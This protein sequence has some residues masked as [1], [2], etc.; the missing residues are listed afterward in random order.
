MQWSVYRIKYN[1]WLQSRNPLCPISF[2]RHEKKPIAAESKRKSK[3]RPDSRKGENHN[4]GS[5]FGNFEMQNPEDQQQK[6]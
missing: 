2:R 5:A 4:R 3:G 6:L 1:C